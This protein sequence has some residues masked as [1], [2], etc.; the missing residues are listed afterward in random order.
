M[1]TLRVEVPIFT[2]TLVFKPLPIP[3]LWIFCG[4]TL[5]LGIIIEP[6][7][8]LGSNHSSETSSSFATCFIS[9]V[10]TPRRAAV[11]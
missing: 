8:I 9:S 5:L 11:I 7:A 2:L 4:L 3:T 6:R 1:F 10:A